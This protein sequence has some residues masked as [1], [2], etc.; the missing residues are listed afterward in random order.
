MIVTE[1]AATI[2]AG[3]EQLYCSDGVCSSTPPPPPDPRYCPGRECFYN[4]GHETDP[5]FGGCLPEGFWDQPKAVI[6][7]R[8]A[9]GELPKI[10]IRAYTKAD[11][12]WQRQHGGSEMAHAFSYWDQQPPVGSAAAAQ[13][14]AQ[15]ALARWKGGVPTLLP[16]LAT[17]H[18]A[19]SSSSGPIPTWA[20]VAAA[21]LAV[22]FFR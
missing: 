22:L 13:G 11:E 8:K 12:S 16:D 5:K 1:T 19:V 17:T 10:I 2:Y 4:K 9:K 14:Q 18:A 7:A 6:Q 15:Q 3:G 21:G 20:W